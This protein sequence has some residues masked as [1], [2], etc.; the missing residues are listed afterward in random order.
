[1][2]RFA[3]KT[4]LVTGGNSGIGLAVALG[5]AREG[6][7]VVIT[8]RDQGSLDVAKESLG[9]GAIALRSDTG[10]TASNKELAQILL[11]Q[12]IS[13]DAVFINAGIAKMAPLS[14]VDEAT[15]QVVPKLV[16]Y[17]NR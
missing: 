12:G 6:A 1:M 17:L 5:F 3:S 4:A 15:E 13:L 10:D 8:G 9:P 11:R 2:N 16:E 14:A 7:R